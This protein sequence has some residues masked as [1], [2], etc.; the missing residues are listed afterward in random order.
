MKALPIA[1]LGAVLA[2]SPALAHHPFASEFDASQPV[3]LA[4]TVAQVD[5]N[6]PH[7]VIHLTTSGAAGN[8][9]WSLE[10]ASPADLARKGWSRDTLKIGEQITVEGYRAK[11]KPMTAA[12]RVVELPGGKKLSAADDQDGGPKSPPAP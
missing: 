9:S 4:G 2:A 3:R 10:A 7:V 1:A 8:Q 6:N 5:W 11:T 12:A